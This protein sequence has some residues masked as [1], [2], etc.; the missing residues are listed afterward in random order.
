VVYLVDDGSTDETSDAIRKQFPQVNVIRADGNLYWSRG[1]RKAWAEAIRGNYEYYLWLN[2]DIELYPVFFQELMECLRYGEYQC[3][4]S[5]LVEDFSKESILYG[6][7]NEL[8]KKIRK[9]D[10]PQSIKYMNGNIVL[11]PKYVVDE[12]GIID[13]VFHHDLGDVDYGLTAIEHGIKVF[14]TRI[15]VAAGYKNDICRVRKWGYSLIPRLKVLHSP[16][17]SPPNINFYFRKKHFG[18]YNALSYCLFLYI[19][20]L[21]PDIIVGKLFGNKY[22]TNIT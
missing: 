20:N 7:S 16:L 18:L 13:P 15:A 19:I 22:K 4:V 5:G 17:G 1:M 2:D 21:M 10:V 3:I 12:I 14:T 11:I 6:G 9:S 8:K